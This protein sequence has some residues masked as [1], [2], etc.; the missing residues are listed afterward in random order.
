MGKNRDECKE[1]L[2]STTPTKVDESR[3]KKR[4]VAAGAGSK[5]D[6]AAKR[7]SSTAIASFS[8]ATLQEEPLS[9]EALKPREASA[10]LGQAVG[11]LC[12]NAL[13]N[14]VV[15]DNNSES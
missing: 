8:N 7:R 6:H 14:S 11:A 15:I 12:S 1:L 2:L 10:S 3:K 4:A 13:D 9:R 5:E